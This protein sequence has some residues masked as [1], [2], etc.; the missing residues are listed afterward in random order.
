MGKKRNLQQNLTEEEQELIRKQKEGTIVSGKN[1]MSEYQDDFI[2]NFHGLKFKLNTKCKTQKQKDFLNMLKNVNKSIC[3]GIGSAGTGKSYISLSYGLSKIKDG[4]YDHIVMVIPTAQASG[5]DMGLGYLKGELEDKTRPFKDV[6][7]HTIEKILKSSENFEYKAL[8]ASLINSGLIQYE[9]INFMLGKTFDH[10]LILVNEAEQ[11]TKDDMKLILTRL[12]E[13]SKII[14]TG[15]VEQV[16]R[17]SIVKKQDVCGLS[18]TA[19]KLSDMDEVGIVEFDRNDI[20]RNPLIGKI[21]D[22]L[23]DK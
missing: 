6:D 8:T 14:I 3:F 10:S 4:T 1:A 12:G 13:G 9:F 20:V 7:R 19:E 11:Y 23:D 2:P 15:D 16:N 22:K 18:F 17:Q 21:L 5:R